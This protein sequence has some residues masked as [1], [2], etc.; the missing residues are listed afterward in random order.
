MRAAHVLRRVPDF[1]GNDDL[2]AMWKGRNGPQQKLAVLAVGVE[3]DAFT[4]VKEAMDKMIAEPKAQMAEEVKIKTHCTDEF[5]QNEKQTF[6]TNREKTLL[7]QKIEELSNTVKRLTQ[8]IADAELQ[9]VNMKLEI[10]KAGQNREAENAEYQTVIAEQRATQE[11]LKKAKARMEAFYKKKA[12][13][14]QD[15]QD[16]MPPVAFKTYRKNAGAS[17]IISFLDMIIEDSKKVET[18]AVSE[19]AEA[20]KNYETFVNDSNK[21]I[22]GLEEAITSKTDEKATADTDRENAKVERQNAMNELEQLA[23][24]LA[25]L[26]AECDFIVNNFDIRQQARRSEIEAIQE[27]KAILSGAMSSGQAKE[28]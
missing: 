4:K 11:I 22:K 6:E 14:M 13:L 17:G 27:A 3:L 23:A 26:H 19:E 10:S 24:Y 12:A 25:D 5:N 20:Q 21:T 7:E 18:D 1:A 15:G 16:P 8:E 9:I 2:E 28:E